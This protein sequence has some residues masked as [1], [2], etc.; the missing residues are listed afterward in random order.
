M[1]LAKST[2]HILVVSLIIL[3]GMLLTSCGRKQKNIFS[4]SHDNIPIVNKLSL[5]VVRG[6]TIQKTKAGNL[7]NWLTPDLS[8]IP[9]EK[10]LLF[11]KNLA[12][13][14]TGFNIYRLVRNNIIPKHPINNK[15]ITTT[16]YLDKKASHQK[17]TLYLVKIVFSI[18]QQ[19]IEGPASA[20]ACI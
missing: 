17:Q 3:F 1:N 9:Q 12:H 18:N 13:C 19:L 11:N 8:K 4:F 2:K 7:I 10:S 20:I 6:V 15:P 16:N 5:P 14:F